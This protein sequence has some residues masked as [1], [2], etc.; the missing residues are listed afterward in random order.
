MEE[1]KKRNFVKTGAG[2]EKYV[3]PK[4]RIVAMDLDFTLLDDKK[5]ISEHTQNVLREAAAAGIQIIPATGRIFKAI[6]EFLR[7]TEGIRYYMCCNGATIYDRVEDKVIYANHM[8][9]ETVFGI[10]G[11]FDKYRCTQDIYRNGQ[12]YMEDRFLDHLGE[13][14]VEGPMYDLVKRTRKSVSDLRA[15][16]E[17]DPFGIEKTQGFFPNEMER[18]ACMAELKELN[19]A[20]VSSAVFNNI[21]VNQFHCDKGDGLTH[22]AAYLGIP[23]EQV[24]ACGDA[25]NDEQMLNAAGFAVVMENGMEELKRKADFITKSNNED[26]VAYAIEKFVL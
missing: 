1:N 25:S 16:I 22:L 12:G 26:G 17:K 19:I 14:G 20:S 13:F 4:I 21:E 23:M 7:T 15:E 5:Q 10:L 9:K 18:Q 6:P 2:Q 3:G 11:V 8:P 24:M